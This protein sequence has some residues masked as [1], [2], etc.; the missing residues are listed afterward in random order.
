L[1]RHKN[2]DAIQKI[3]D[4]FRC[5]G[6]ANS[7]DMAWPFPDRTHNQHAC[8]TAFGRNSGC[9]AAWKAEEQQIAGLLMAVVGMV[10]VWQVR[11]T[12]ARSVLDGLKLAR[13][14][15]CVLTF[16]LVCHNCYTD[17]KRIVVAPRCS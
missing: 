1:F 5:C 8:E 17:P 2:A 9:L 3:Q 10:F 12:L 11:S 7:H 14:I 15:L 6:F 16:V 13:P 4:A